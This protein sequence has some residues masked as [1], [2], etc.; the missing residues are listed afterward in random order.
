LRNIASMAPPNVASAHAAKNTTKNAAPRAILA[1]RETGLRGSSN[2]GYWNRRSIISCAFGSFWITRL[3]L[4]TR[5][6]KSTKGLCS[7]A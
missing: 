1:P 7:F 6:A 2:L 5:T 4:S 3:N